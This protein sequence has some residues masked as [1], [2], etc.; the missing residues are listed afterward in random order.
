MYVP[1]AIARHVGS[2]TTVKQSDF[3][4]YHGH[5][6]MVWTFVKNMPGRLFWIYLPQHLALNIAT[7]IWFAL[8]GRGRVILRASGMR[9]ADC[10]RLGQTARIPGA[11]A[12][13]VSRVSARCWPAEC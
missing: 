10:E 4:V 1:A 7:V 9:C 2:A 3:C 12:R 5:R 6:N 8:Q 11:A 13:R